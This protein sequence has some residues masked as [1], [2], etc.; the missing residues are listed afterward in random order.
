MVIVEKFSE[1]IIFDISQLF[2]N[3]K[4]KQEAIS[5]I[6]IFPSKSYLSCIIKMPEVWTNCKGCIFVKPSIPSLNG[7]G[8][9]CFPYVT[10]S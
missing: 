10:Q 9:G 8:T 7:Y 2:D 6:N 5:I 4:E 3:E 1:F